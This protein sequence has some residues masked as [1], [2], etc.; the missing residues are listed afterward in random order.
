MIE[1]VHFGKPLLRQLNAEG[2]NC[3]DMH[4]H[5]RYSDT[6]TRIRNILK[7]CSKLGIGV[8]ITDHNEIKGC[9]DALSKNKEFG[10]TIIPGMEVSCRE[11]PHFLVYFYSLSELKE[12]HEKV[13]KKNLTKNPHISRI[14]FND[15]ME[16]TYDYNCI[17]SAA[18]PSSIHPWN[19][20]KK[21][22]SNKLDSKHIK[23]I[24]AFEVLSGMCMRHMNLRAVE[25]AR[26]HNKPIT[27]GSDGH[28]LRRLGSVVSCSKAGT[29]EEFLDS[30]ARKKNILIGEE[31][32]R[33]YRIVSNFK[34]ISKQSRYAG[35]SLKAHYD[36]RLR[37]KLRPKMQQKFNGF[38]ERMNRKRNG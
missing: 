8:A 9:A 13:I 32:K 14:R 7:K 12:Y 11:G 4:Y 31:T 23:R 1:R 6:Y 36:M 34:S 28:T 5:T 17:I 10:N 21:F 2:Y 3:V 20:Q 18:H 29:A 27:G 33:T 26:T 25:W 35:C 22:E 15:L 16:K 37:G 38:Q 30:I 24:S 19:T